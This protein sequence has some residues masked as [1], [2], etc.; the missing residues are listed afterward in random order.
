MGPTLQALTVGP[1]VASLDHAKPI[2]LLRGEGRS[3]RPQ[4]RLNHHSVSLHR[5]GRIRLAGH[6]C[7]GLDVE[8]P[9]VHERGGF[10]VWMSL[11]LVRTGHAIN[12]LMAL[13]NEAPSQRHQTKERS[14]HRSGAFVMALAPL[15]VSRASH[16][17][18]QLGTHLVGDP[19]ELDPAASRLA[20]SGQERRRGS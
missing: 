2:Q 18:L 12:G 6:I 10:L 13:H 17:A 7:Q 11:G 9:G 14:T 8:H 5:H 20:L 1:F 4:P 19:S 16:D 3:L 15:W